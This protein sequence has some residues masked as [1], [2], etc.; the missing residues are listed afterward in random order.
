M[1]TIFFSLICG[2][3]FVGVVAF[4]SMMAEGL[5]GNIENA[6]IFF[7]TAGTFVFGCVVSYFIVRKTMKKMQTD[8][9]KMME[10]FD[11]DE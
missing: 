2:F 7:L 5:S 9:Q 1:M 4:I 11:D 6:P 8:A 10:S 3:A